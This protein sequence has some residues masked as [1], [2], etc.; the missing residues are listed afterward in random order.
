MSEHE[1]MAAA[2]N[3][4]NES[5]ALELLEQHPNLAELRFVNDG[6]Q[7]PNTDAKILQH[8]TLLK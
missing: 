5:A 3:E 1:E 2:L 4:G 7:L 6:R 8:A